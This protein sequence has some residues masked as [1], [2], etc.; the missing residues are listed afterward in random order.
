MTKA[1]RFDSYG[2]IENLYVA[3]VEL[4]EPAE[5]E[6]QVRV[7]AAGINPGEAAI[8]KGLLADFAP[9]AFPSGQ[10]SDFA[11]VVD[12][13]GPGVST[14]SVGDEVLGWNFTRSSQAE[15]TNVP[16]NQLVA[17]P[18]G[19]SWEAAGSLYVVGATAFAAV[20]AVG[21]GTGD[22][23]VVSAAAG[24]VG[25]VTAQLLKVRGAEVI[26][27]ASEANHEWLRSKG[28]T[29][30]AYGDGLADRI[31]GLAPDG[32]DAFIDTFGPDYVHLAVDLGIARDRID[33]I[34]AFEAAA[35]LGVKAEGSSAATTQAVLA[36]MAD[37]VASG[38]IELPIAAT[39]PLDQVQAAFTEL[40]KRHTRG[41]I[42][43]V[44]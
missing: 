14:V 8:R 2:P 33:T 23:V 29:P 34:I 5:G 35:E 18:A 12:K 13:L 37:H 4:P 28:V 26:G 39:Y 27:I 11:G 17:K 41:K 1:V 19:L 25:S 16:A 30:V 44:P 21:A 22:T 7:V 15:R 32:V 24:G 36:E 38:R 10:G 43:L 9:S 20:R 31:R 3:D 6:V 40:E 42:V